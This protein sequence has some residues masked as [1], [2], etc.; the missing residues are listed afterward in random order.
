MAGRP[1]KEFDKK[2][3]VNLVGM[4]C[5]QEEICWWFRDDTG[6]RRRVSES[7]ST[8]NGLAMAHCRARSSAASPPRK[9]SRHRSTRRAWSTCAERRSSPTSATS[10]F[11]SSRAKTASPIA[12]NLRK[13]ASSRTRGRT[14]PC[15]RR[16]GAGFVAQAARR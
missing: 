7:A 5:T 4:G 16:R 13:A 6:T 9:R 3:F 1:V 12:S 8:G 15:R 11:A 14:S 10:P 2:E